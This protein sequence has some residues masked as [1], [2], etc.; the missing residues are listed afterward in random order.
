MESLREITDQSTR[1]YA[2][3]PAFRARTEEGYQTFTFSDAAQAIN[4]IQNHLIS[5]GIAT[6]DR[7][8]IMAENRPEWPMAY[9]AVTA[10]GAVAVPYSTQ[11]SHPA[12]QWV[13]M[14][15]V[16]SGFFS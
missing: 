1:R 5:L 2:A 12:L 10:M 7:V 15:T 14:F 3:S 8:A 9:L 13:R 4:R 11:A 6:G 16:F